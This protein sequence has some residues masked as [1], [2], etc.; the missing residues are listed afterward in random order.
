MEL[1]KNPLDNSLKCVKTPLGCGMFI[2]KTPLEN[3]IYSLPDRK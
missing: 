1:Y 2:V 3:D